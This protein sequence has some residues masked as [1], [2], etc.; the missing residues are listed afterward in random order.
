M[1]TSPP[2]S[3]SGPPIPK[4]T[5]TTTPPIVPPGPPQ[6][7]P[8]TRPTQ[9]VYTP[10]PPAATGTLSAV[11]AS[12]KASIS[13]T[14]DQYGLGSLADQAW[15]SYL[16]GV[17]IEQIMLDIRS[18]KE[19]QARFPAMAQLQKEGRAITEQQYIDYERTAAQLFTAHGLPKGFYD[20]PKD[21]A[22]LLVGDVS[23]TELDKRLGEAQVLAYSAPQEVR[24]T[25]Q[26]YFGVQGA[27]NLTA[28]YIDPT[29]TEP[30]LAKQLTQAQIGAE[31]GL[32]GFGQLTSEQ[33]ARLADLGVTESTAGQGFNNLASLGQVTSTNLAGETALTPDQL[34]AAQFAGDTGVQQKIKARQQARV[35]Q[36]QAG[37]GYTASNA[38][39]TGIGNAQ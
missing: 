39:T 23:A 8:Q 12:A 28:H 25:F 26:R 18:S 21:I 1:A 37:G 33:A 4:P 11:D 19:Y 6:P 14:L 30:I 36:F 22:D 27:G 35:A 5:T 7:P 29:L 9:A 20:T 17:P 24:D 10:P 13:A 16:K 32:T 15:Q 34:L 2:G 31:A 38:G 3:T